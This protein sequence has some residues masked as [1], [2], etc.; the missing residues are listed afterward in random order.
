MLS[1]RAQ[2][3]SP[4]NITFFSSSL[5]DQHTRAEIPS[6]LS[7]QVYLTDL[8]AAS[9]L[10]VDGGNATAEASAAT[11]VADATSTLDTPQSASTSIAA[12]GQARAPEST[13]EQHP[14]APDE[15][16][17][18]LKG[19][20]GGRQTD[21]KLGISLVVHK[22]LHMQELM[23]FGDISRQKLQH[24]VDQITAKLLAEDAAD[25][26]VESASRFDDHL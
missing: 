9:K 20:D 14:E 15:L 18:D 23:V 24:A 3:V 10:A 16:H 2:L 21:L 11:A 5:R 22:G 26:D 13:S 4:V 6:L 25:D 7:E 12:S 1:L 8:A 17:D 19:L